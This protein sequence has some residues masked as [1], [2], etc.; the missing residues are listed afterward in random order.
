[1]KIEKIDENKIRA[2][3]SMRDL[4]DKNIDLHSFMSDSS[5]SQKLFLD[6]LDEAESKFRICY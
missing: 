3:F 6:L 2:T 1:M 4:N 5:E